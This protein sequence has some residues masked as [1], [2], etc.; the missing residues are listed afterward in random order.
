MFH[1]HKRYSDFIFVEDL[2]V[3]A[4]LCSLLRSRRTIDVFPNISGIVESPCTT[5]DSIP[6]LSSGRRSR[7]STCERIDSGLKLSELTLYEAGL[8]EAGAEEC[9]VQSDEDPG[10]LLEGDGGEEDT[11]PEEDLQDGDETHGGIVVFFY[12][13]ADEVSGW[14]GFVGWLSTWGCGGSGDL[15]GLEGGN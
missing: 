10:A 12:E 4:R 13:L 8:S 7:L 11:A 9:G 15:R 6:N 2:Q 5:L 1:L 14:V 3:K